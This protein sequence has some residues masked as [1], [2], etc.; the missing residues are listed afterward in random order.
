MI[1]HK[2]GDP[3]NYSVGMLLPEKTTV[4]EG[5]EYHDFPKG[6]LGVCWVYSK[7]NEVHGHGD[8]RKTLFENYAI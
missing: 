8:L 7:Q 1:Q 4:P 5:F 6:T 3:F 2:E